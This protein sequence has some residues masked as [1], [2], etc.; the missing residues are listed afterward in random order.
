MVFG[1]VVVVFGGVVVEVTLFSSSFVFVSS[2]GKISV[3][4]TNISGLVVGELIGLGML[5]PTSELSK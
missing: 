4:L 1:G 2:C 5:F 3:G